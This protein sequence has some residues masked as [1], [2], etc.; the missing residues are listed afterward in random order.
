VSVHRPV[1]LSSPAAPEIVS[2]LVLRRARCI[3]VAGD[4][5]VVPGPKTCRSRQGVRSLT[6]LSG[7]E[8][9]DHRVCGE[10]EID[11]VGGAPPPFTVSLPSPG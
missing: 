4:H 9:D 8:V 1:E 5:V 10:E 3:Q 7:G 11:E 6:G 2:V